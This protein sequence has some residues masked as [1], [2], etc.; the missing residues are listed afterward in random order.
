MGGNAQAGAWNYQNKTGENPPKFLP[1]FHDNF[2]L[3]F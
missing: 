1:F 2:I 3:K